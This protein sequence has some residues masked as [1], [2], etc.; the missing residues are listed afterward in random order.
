M[1]DTQKLGQICELNSLDLLAK[2]IVGVGLAAPALFFLETCKPLSTLGYTASLAFEPFALPFL[3]NERIRVL[4]FLLS[5]RKNVEALERF[6]E[7]HA[8]KKRAEVAS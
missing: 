1:Q 3:G 8:L 5:E 4:Q 6:I 7:Q 2:R